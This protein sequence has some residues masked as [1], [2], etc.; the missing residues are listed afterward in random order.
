MA[1]KILCFN[2]SGY[3]LGVEQDQVEKI[4]IN[5]HPEKDSFVL[6]TGVE[7][8]SLKY[9]IPLP[10]REPA[11]AGNIFFLKDQKDFYGFTV[12]RI[13]GYLTLTGVERIRPR[14]V[15]SPVKYFV[16]NDSKLIPVL[17]LQYIT[18]NVNS[19]NEEELAEIASFSY[20]GS[21]PESQESV[22]PENLEEVSKDEIFR[23]IDEEIQ[24]RKSSGSWEEAVQSEK[25]GIVLPLV[26]NA[27]I[28]VIVA[29]GILFYF[30]SGRR[31][32]SEGGTEGS[33]GGVEEAVIEAIRR[34]SEE[35]IAAERERLKEAQLKLN[36]LEMERDSFV[37]NQDELLRQRERNLDEEFQRR[38]EDARRR[39]E[40]SGVPNADE[41]FAK[42]R[43]RLTREY[44]ESRN[45]IRGETDEVKKQFDKE[46]QQREEALK[47]DM[48]AVTRRIDEMNE[49]L[50]EEAAKV[51]AAEEAARS[52]ASQQQEYLAFRRQLNTL[53]NRALVLFGQ[54]DYPKGV[55]ELKKIPP[56]IENA[57]ARNVVDEATL[58]VEDDLVKN[59]RYLAER[60]QGRGKFEEI[61]LKTYESAL[62]FERE[63]K[64]Q[65]ALSR[66]FTVYTLVGDQALRGKS[67]ARA[68]SI[69]DSL[70]KE[71]TARENRELERKA[72]TLFTAALES[73]RRG[74]TDQALEKLE[75]IILRYPAPALSGKVLDEIVLINGLKNLQAGSRDR[76]GLN[77]KAL[78]TM[79]R[80]KASY[81][82]GSYSEAIAGYEEVVRNYRESD[83]T[84]DALAQI[85]RINEEMR[86]FK[87]SPSFTLKTGE[88]KTG[89][90]VQ[91]LP[92]NSIL[93]S[94]GAEEGVKQGDVLQLFRKETTGTA[95]Y[96]GSAKVFEVNP[97]SSKCR[98][99]YFDRALKVGDVVSY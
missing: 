43:E 60:E 71:R 96:I 17:D 24:K 95:S 66:Y 42:E 12:D 74:E 59:L 99:V 67:E 65:E 9:Y 91:L 77:A 90:L 35:E 64:L 82:S 33:I 57:R 45:K 94:M 88:V 46:L 81:D 80:A 47:K 18:N 19:V 85:M 72:S 39:I 37:K 8:K 5:K 34:K 62:A 36:R 10:E 93:I 70:F 23:A 29:V 28:I 69:M 15:Q 52:V 53:Y 38:L 86:K 50:S 75:E 14:R 6:E 54:G 13:L 98:I 84:D 1:D 3:S 40:Q 68:Q 7:V 30:V 58:R 87:F 20:G 48:S 11:S 61:G 56:I 73:K 49:K 51:K 41:V 89:V 79:N 31:G 4:L 22:L 27:V 21:G 83:Y 32:V 97:K 63:G 26:V 44:L 76:T 2:L 25:K 78:E 55:E 16:K 92:E